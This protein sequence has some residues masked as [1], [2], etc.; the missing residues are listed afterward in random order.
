MIW[1][2]SDRDRTPSDDIQTA[3]VDESPRN[4]LEYLITFPA[5]E[6]GV[7]HIYK[8]ACDYLSVHG[9]R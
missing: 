9:I 8:C 1:V 4:S 3:V 6:E 5:G 2:S 7:S